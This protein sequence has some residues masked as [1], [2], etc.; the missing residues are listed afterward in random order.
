MS[1]KVR[2]D[3]PGDTGF[4][5][6]ELVSRK[7]SY[8]ENAKVQFEGGRQAQGS[9]LYRYIYKGQFL[10]YARQSLI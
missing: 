1:G 8:E 7:E 9:P 4:L 5:I 2:I 3:D 6:G 10:R